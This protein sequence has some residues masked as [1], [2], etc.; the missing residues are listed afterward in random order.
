MKNKMGIL[1]MSE[2]FLFEGNHFEE[3]IRQFGIKIIGVEY[4]VYP[5]YF[6]YKCVSSYFEKNI[7]GEA[8]PEYTV[9]VSHENNIFKYKIKKI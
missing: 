7:E 2:E 5:I 1:K 3:I 6:T 4:S 8:I 9:E